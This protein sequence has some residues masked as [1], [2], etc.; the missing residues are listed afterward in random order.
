MI[1]I[2][3]CQSATVIFNE[4]CKTTFKDFKT[5]NPNNNFMETVT[6]YKEI[7]SHCKE[8]DLK[9]VSVKQYAK[10]QKGLLINWNRKLLH[11]SDN[12][13]NNGIEKKLAIVIFTSY[14]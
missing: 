12:F 13:I 5:K 1:P 8:E 3:N 9:Y 11:A 6:N 14:I 4:E 10:W 2:D 7:L